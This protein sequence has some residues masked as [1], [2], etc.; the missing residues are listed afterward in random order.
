MNRWSRRVGI[1]KCGQLKKD[2]SVRAM[3]GLFLLWETEISQQVKAVKPQPNN[4]TGNCAACVW[5]HLLEQQSSD[6][7]APAEPAST[8]PTQLRHSHKQPTQCETFQRL[9]LHRR[10][11][12]KLRTSPLGSRCKVAP[13]WW[14]ASTHLFP[15]ALMKLR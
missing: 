9:Q 15:P 2:S 6:G 5:K 8:L 13:C 4:Q 7:S 10:N 12:N 11:T 3:T 1:I 14:K